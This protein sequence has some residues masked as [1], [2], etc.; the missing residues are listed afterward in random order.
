MSRRLTFLVCFAV[1]L[2]PWVAVN[3][4]GYL[5]A[6]RCCEG[7]GIMPVGLPAVFYTGG[8][9][10]LPGG[11][12]WDALAVNALCATGVSLVSARILQSVFRPAGGVEL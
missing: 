4:S 2:L 5:G 8:G 1:S 7:D 9:W 3:L 11:I 12:M 6:L 10:S